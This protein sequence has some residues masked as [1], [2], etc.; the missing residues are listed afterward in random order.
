[1]RENLHTLH[2]HLTGETQSITAAQGRRGRGY[3]DGH[4]DESVRRAKWISATAAMP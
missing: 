4:P 2:R 3:A 1:M